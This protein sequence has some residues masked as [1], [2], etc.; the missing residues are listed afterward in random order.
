M[1]T[2]ETVPATNYTGFFDIL[3][4]P[5][6]KWTVQVHY[7]C[8]HYT[9]RLLPHD[10]RGGCSAEGGEHCQKKDKNTVGCRPSFPRGKCPQVILTGT[11]HSAIELTLR[12]QGEVRP[13]NWCTHRVA[14]PRYPYASP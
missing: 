9:P 13:R 3:G 2:A 12:A 10:N 11:E 7:F 14:L 6:E 5:R 1:C 4:L 8:A